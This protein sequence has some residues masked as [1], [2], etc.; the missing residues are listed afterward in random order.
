MCSSYWEHWRIHVHPQ[1]CHP[2]H[3]TTLSVSSFW[4][5]ITGQMDLWDPCAKSRSF[6]WK[7]CYVAPCA[8]GPLYRPSNSSTSWVPT[9]WKGKYTQ[10]MH[11]IQSKWITVLSKAQGLAAFLE[12]RLVSLT[13]GLDIHQLSWQTQVHYWALAQSSSVICPQHFVDQKEYL[14][15]INENQIIRIYILTT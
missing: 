7:Q 3:L 6:A 13:V 14:I 10:N 1:L 8:D 12:G 9:S 15:I 4:M 5:V 2:D 11:Q